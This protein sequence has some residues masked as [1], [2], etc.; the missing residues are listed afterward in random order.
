MKILE[1]ANVDF[2][3]V[4][5]VAPLMR[6]M[7]ARGHEVQAASADGPMLAGLRAE[8]FVVYALPLR[9]SLNP[10]S[11]WRGFW[12]LVWLIRRERPDMVH[13]HFPVS[14]LLGRAAA[15]VCGVRCIAFTGH[16]FMFQQGGS[17]LTRAVGFAAEWVSGFWTDIYLTVSD[18]AAADARRLGISSRAIPVGNGRDPAR[19]RPDPEA[20][21]RL[22][23]AM[24]VP[25]DRVVVVFTGRLVRV[26]GIPELLA[27]M[28]EAPEA[29][30][31][32]VGERL[33][34]DRGEDME[35]ACAAS[36]LG[37][38]LR[39]LGYRDDVEAVLAAAD[40]F[41]LPSFYEALPMSVVEAMLCGLPV[42]A[43]R[44]RGPGEQVV[45]GE[46]GLLVALGDVPALAAALRL[47][48]GDAALRAR[49]GQAGRAR[50]LARY[51]ESAVLARTLDLLGLGA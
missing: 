6:E 8:G 5:F 11:L 26:K 13:A 19:F 24:A 14:A 28:R 10:V 9:R 47:L 25:E 37:G 2:A 15:W 22:R 49:M 1:I 45:D 34:S 3:L 30:L 18:E 46:T 27:A 23:A 39:M 12:A 7:R 41:A 50:G 17:V 31:W 40:I 20:R 33:E 35:A 16:G 38:R 29:E 32:I 48:A 4:Q 51:D 43:T 42:V 21:T 36:G 44:V